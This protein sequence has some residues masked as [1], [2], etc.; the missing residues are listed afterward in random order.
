[1]ETSKKTK[2][3]KHIDTYILLLD[4]QNLKVLA[5][6][7]N[8]EVEVVLVIS[9]TVIDEMDSKKS[10]MDELGF[11][12]REFGRLISSAEL[13]NTREYDD[14]SVVEL[15]LDGIPIEIA[16]KKEYTLNSTDNSSIS[17]DLKI[18]EIVQTYSKAFIERQIFISN[19]VMARIRATSLGI[20]TSSLV[21]VS[22]SNFDF[23][24][25]VKVSP[26]IFSKI[27]N[28]S[29]LTIY[30]I[31]KDYVRSNYNYTVTCEETNQQKLISVL[32]NKSIDYISKERETDLRRQEASPIN[33]GQLFFSNA[34]QSEAYDIIVCE[35]LSGSGKT[36]CAL[37]NAMKLVKAKKYDCIYYIR[38]SVDDVPKSE[39]QGFRRGSD[40]EKNGIFF[41][42]LEDSLDFMVRSKH[43]SS[44]LKA[45]ELEIKIS[46]EKEALM[47][48]Y[49]IIPLTALGLRG[50]TLRANSIVIFE[51]IQNASSSSF[52]KMLTRVGKESMIICIGSQ[53]QID[54]P[55]LN[56][57]NNGLSV[58]LDSCTKD[59]E[60]DVN[61]YGVTLHKVARS[62]V[63][64]FA[65]KLF[66]NKLQ[67]KEG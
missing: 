64:E 51:E 19:D 33:K 29:N 28:N 30:D 63:S 48:R 49:N 16:S 12:A 67:L 61:L 9:E 46:S 36:I 47:K 23:T 8:K 65:E 22:E 60:T 50:R 41:L 26:D 2:I 35:S 15:I 25:E 52:Q 21:E 17:N 55:Y 43:K 1:M 31:D 18:I 58:L 42:P 40:E 24:K 34:I 5:E 56:R 62:A 4:V 39:A 38:N 53:N 57:Y 14:F 45:E 37:S 59:Y 27:R 3:Y 20:E 32:P 44:K 7:D 11:N 6:K 66:T 13:L 54:N 10:L